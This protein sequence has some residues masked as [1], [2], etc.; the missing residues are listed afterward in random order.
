MNTMNIS[1]PDSRAAFVDE[2]VAH[3][4]STEYMC[5]WIRKGWGRARLRGLLL[6]CAASAPGKL[7][8]GAYFS[9]LRE[10]AGRCCGK[11]TQSGSE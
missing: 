3:G 9:K 6:Q 11:Y 5:E 7:A 1:L 10:R 2:R 4:T 8:D